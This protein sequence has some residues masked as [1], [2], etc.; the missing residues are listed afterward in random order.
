M[1]QNFSI[2]E[3]PESTPE[4]K[5]FDRKYLSSTNVFENNY[6]ITPLNLCVYPYSNVD[7]TNNIYLL[8]DNLASG[9]CSFFKNYNFNMS[10]NCET[11]GNGNIS[12]ITRMIYP[13]Q[14]YFENNSES[15]FKEAYCY[16]NNVDESK[17]LDKDSISYENISELYKDELDEI[18]YLN[19]GYFTTENIKIL[20]KQYPYEFPK[21]GSKEDMLEFLKQK[22][23][24]SF[25]EEYEN[26]FY[27]AINFFGLKVEISNS[28]HFEKILYTKTYE[29]VDQFK[30]SEDI[31]SI[32]DCLG[33][34]MYNIVM[35]GLF[36]NWQEFPEILVGRVIFIDRLTGIN[37]TSNTI[38]ITKEQYKYMINNT[39]L[40]RLQSLVNI[41]QN[42]MK[43]ITLTSAINPADISMIIS[44]I[45]E[46]L[47][48]YTSIATSTL[49]SI[50][51]SVINCVEDGLQNLD[52][53]GF[54]FINNLNCYV[55]NVST[56]SE[57]TAINTNGKQ[58]IIY[59]PIFYKVNKLQNIQ[60][61]QQKKQNIGIDLHEYMSKVDMF[62][63]SLDNNVFYEVARNANYVIFEINGAKLQNATGN[64]E[65]YDE[66]DNY[67]TYGNWS[68]VK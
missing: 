45:D 56:S 57:T 3:N 21:D 11:D 43:E 18:E 66:N 28:K 40:H 53:N 2:V 34:G 55:Q 4:E 32:Y 50:K 8:N 12:F 65:I 35:T 15:S 6:M 37:I 62:T 33:N 64:Y 58:K 7:N 17:Y 16:F 23:L 44:N 27:A 30:S 14:E 5:I 47:S 1:T 39:Y 13:G 54:N 46:T 49:N 68:I 36:K 59:K 48:G 9:N 67:I 41:N 61:K 26:E 24:E 63:L 31:H 38:N 22:R 51:E 52:I 20:S 19:E 60:I 42:S 29:F 10:L 25:I